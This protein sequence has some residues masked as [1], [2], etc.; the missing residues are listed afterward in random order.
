MP[1]RVVDGEVTGIY[2][3]GGCWLFANTP[4]C[5]TP[6]RYERAAASINCHF[7][8]IKCL[9]DREDDFGRALGGNMVWDGECGVAGHL[10]SLSRLREV[11]AAVRKERAADA[12][13]EKKA[14]EEERAEDRRAQ[15]KMSKLEYEAAAHRLRKNQEEAAA[16]ARK[17]RGVQGA[18]AAMQATRPTMATQAT[19]KTTAKGGAKAKAQAKA[20][21][22][23]L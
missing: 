9:C 4:T 12:D 10:T 2:N 11:C 1:D 23:E 3:R 18:T 5:V 16:A 6:W 20:G 17:L 7:L 8:N 13:A 14:K 22:R 19:A 15:A 21:G